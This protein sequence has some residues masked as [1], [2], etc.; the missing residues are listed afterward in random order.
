MTDDEF[1]TGF[2]AGRMHAVLVLRGAH[3]GEDFRF[4][5]HILESNGDGTACVS[6]EGGDEHEV[7]V[8]DL[9]WPANPRWRVVW[10]CGLTQSTEFVHA[11]TVEAA[12]AR[13]NAAYVPQGGRVIF[14]APEPEEK[15]T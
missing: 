14:A 13:A 3:S 10:Q 6:G 7:F 8:S 2:T 1:K 5:V 4:P 12:I 11:T 15:P 9:E